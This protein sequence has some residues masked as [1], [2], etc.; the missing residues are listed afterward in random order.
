MMLWSFDNGSSAPK[1]IFV[2]AVPEEDPPQEIF[3]KITHL[4]PQMLALQ[5]FFF[6]REFYH[7]FHDQAG[8][9]TGIS[10]QNFTMLSAMV[11]GDD[12]NMQGDVRERF[13]EAMISADP[14]ACYDL[15]F[16][17]G[18]EVEFKEFLKEF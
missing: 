15:R 1:S 14:E 7:Q 9:V 8:S 12:R 2:M 4:K 17:N 18:S 16:F 6:P 10:K 3:N 13:E 11:M 5:K